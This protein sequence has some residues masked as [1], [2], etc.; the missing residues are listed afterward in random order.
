[1]GVA[2]N[3]FCR[4]PLFVTVPF[5]AELAG[6]IDAKVPIC[7]GSEV[8]AFPRVWCFCLIWPC[9]QEE[10]EIRAATVV[11]TDKICA[12][13][14]RSDSGSKAHAIQVDWMLWQDGEARKDDLPPH[15]RTLTCFY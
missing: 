1:M 11:A 12:V 10:V 15:H 2:A 6:K 7:A 5:V 4:S 13:L 3:P 9:A 14:N 8:R